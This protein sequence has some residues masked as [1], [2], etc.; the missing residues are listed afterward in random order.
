M[1]CSL[2]L[3]GLTLFSTLP[4]QAQLGGA[5][6]PDWAEA[7]LAEYE[8]NQPPAKA[9]MWRLLD[10]TIIAADNKGRITIHRRVIQKVL[11][12]H[13]VDP[14][15]VYVVDGD[16]TTTKIKRLKGWHRNSRGRTTKLDKANVV[17]ISQAEINKVTNDASTA[18]FF[19]KVG[20]GSV[21]VFESKESRQAVFS[22]DLV[23]MLGNFPI[24]KRII[25]VRLP[26]A[27]LQPVNLDS[28]KLSH[29]IR[30][31]R[32]T[33]E[34]APAVQDEW[35]TADSGYYL[36][37][38]IINHSLGSE[39]QVSFKDWSTLG[40]WYF[41]AFTE[42]AQFQSGGEPMADATHLKAVFAQQQKAISYRQ[43][44]LT[45]GRGWIPAPGADVQ[46]RKYGDCKDMVACLGFEASRNKIQVLPV[47]AMIYSDYY[48]DADK[49][50]SPFAFNHVLAAI[51][52]KE[53]L[54]FAAEI[55]MNDQRYLLIDPTSKGTPLGYLPADYAGRSVFL[56]HK[57][58]GQWLAVPDTALEKEELRVQVFARCD[59]NQTLGG[60]LIITSRGNALGLR[61]LAGNH[62]PEDVEWM[63]RR[64][65]DIPG[66]A[67]LTVSDVDAS[68][69]GEMKVTCQAMWP[70]FFRHDAH[71]YRLPR[72]I[73]QRSRAQ[74]ED[75]GKVRQQAIRISPQVPTT[76]V[77]SLNMARPLTPGS[78]SQTWTD[79]TRRF[80]WQAEGGKNLK[81]TYHSAGQKRLF[82]KS[83]LQSGIDYWEHYRD[84]YNAFYLNATLF[85]EQQG[86]P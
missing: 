83:E 12:E 57:D 25:D 24:A 14:A 21:I 73:V 79:D 78:A 68:V 28:W 65:L 45:P 59:K 39:L 47:L 23:F 54:G 51:P 53:S 75:R 60:S 35:M 46:R 49:P 40:Q 9:N 72:S 10:E 26:E 85:L 67:V 31:S 7:V 55:T 30:G 56:C 52:L 84:N 8:N 37:Y 48:P 27:R 22:Q 42:N 62:N 34:N 58:G 70:S 41:K 33:A 80:E 44:Y 82:A 5:S 77:M 74:L 1:R 13:G 63:V 32:L 36:P 11:T 2:I 64:E 69:P 29:K 15:S 86:T 66:T 20:R 17:T 38:L 19:E 16:P 3:I 6:L 18:A 4:A 43:R 71:G 76:W 50:V 81:V 61:N